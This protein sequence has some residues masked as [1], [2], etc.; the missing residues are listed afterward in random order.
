MESTIVVV[1]A[2]VSGLTSAL[3][4]ARVNA[5]S[6]TVVGKHM[7]GDYDIE[8]ASPWA[9]ANFSPMARK[10]HNR[11]EIRTWP[12]L[13]R[14][15]EEVPEAGIHLQ[16][17]RIY[18]REKDMEGGLCIADPMFDAD[19]WYKGMFP[20]YRELGADEIIPGHDSGREFTSVCINTA[21][22]LQWLLGQCL[23]CGVVVRRAVLTHLAEAR[24]LSHTGRPADVIVNATGLGSARL[25]GVQDTAMTPARGQTVLVRN[26][27][28]PMVST[29]GTD[30]GNAEILYVMQR[31]GGG[32]T[33]LGGTYDLGNWESAPDPNIA[34]RIMRR[35]VEACPHLVGGA[36]RGIEAL[37]IV[38]H[39][40]GLRP[41][42]PFGVRIE[43]E[44]LLSWKE[45]DKAEAPWVV[46]NY[47]HA[48]WGY[49][50]SYGC[51]ELV[52]ELVGQCLH[53][54]AAAAFEGKSN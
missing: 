10:S 42:R 37:S 11:W 41:Y 25:G 18:R 48:G 5:G 39:N 21:T 40:V 30:D 7:P 32:G 20:D 12:E 29:S 44:R 49:Q 19:P 36:G 13:K 27:C 3:L 53:D 35:A 52:V 14:L 2:G 38:R 28:T 8:Y 45:R 24:E 9:G 17:Y 33:I 54:K 50:G 22:Y 51:A 31:A 43:R 16:K 6:I 4:L 15:A 26:E 47:G 23:K 46:H 34:V 1:G